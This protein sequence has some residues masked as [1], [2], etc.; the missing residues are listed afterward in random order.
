MKEFE[1]DLRGLMNYWDVTYREVRYIRKYWERGN[2]SDGEALDELI[3]KIDE[4][5]FLGLVRTPRYLEV[6]DRE[7]VGIFLKIIEG[8]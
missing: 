3:E 2:L 1:E 7:I 4:P 8:K 5:L 6:T